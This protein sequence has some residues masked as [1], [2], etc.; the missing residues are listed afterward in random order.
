MGLGCLA[1]ASKVATAAAP[2][3]ATTG[4]DRGLVGVR[5]VR[6]SQPRG[7]SIAPVQFTHGSAIDHILI[8]W[9]SVISWRGYWL[10]LLQRNAEWTRWMKTNGFPAKI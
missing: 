10:E 6:I 2:L 8:T 3:A 7:I 4:S 5:P 1:M 9:V